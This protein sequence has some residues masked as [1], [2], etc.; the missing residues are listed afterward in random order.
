MMKGSLLVLISVL[1]LCG[2]IQRKSESGTFTLCQLGKREAIRDF[3]GGKLLFIRNGSSL[4][5][6][7]IFEVLLNK[8]GIDYSHNFLGHLYLECYPG[9]MDSLMKVR[10][11]NKFFE[12]LELIADSLFF[13]E[14]RNMTFQYYEVDTWAMR[15]NSGDHLGG[16]FIIN[17]LNERLP[18][19]SSFRFVSNT[20]NRP[21]YVVEFVI[22][23]LGETKHVKMKGGNNV[24]KFKD[25]EKFILNA[26]DSIR[27][28]MPASVRGQP[29]TAKFYKGVAIESSTSLSRDLKL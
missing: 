1:I 26:I 27:D 20:V 4:R 6:D 2:C 25:A 19:K 23:K 14:R 5:Y 16:D 15:I 11:G 28:W 3:G 7:S 21:Y 17:Y 22:D 18:P 9:T 12:E 24:E 8:N 10:F 13:E 29:V